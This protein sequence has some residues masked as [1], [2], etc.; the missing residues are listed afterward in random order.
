MASRHSCNLGRAHSF[1][2]SE[3]VVNGFVSKMAS[4]KIRHVLSE[5]FM[6]PTVINIKN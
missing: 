1:G 2:G 3:P 5:I 6:D 4:S